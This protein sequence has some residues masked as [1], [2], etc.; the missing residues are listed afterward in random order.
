MGKIHLTPVD[1]GVGLR[2]CAV[3]QPTES[4]LTNQ[5]CNRGKYQEK[6]ELVENRQLGEDAQN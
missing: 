5:N 3:N 1:V 2:E 6:W 4:E